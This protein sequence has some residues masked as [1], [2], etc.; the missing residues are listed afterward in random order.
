[1]VPPGQEGKR[2][3]QGQTHL[4]G[5]TCSWLCVH[6]V[7][8]YLLSEE[9]RYLTHSGNMLAKFLSSTVEYHQ[10]F[11]RAR[12]KNMKDKRLEAAE[13]IFKHLVCT[14]YC[15]Q[16]FTEVGKHFFRGFPNSLVFLSLLHLNHCNYIFKAYCWRLWP[17]WQGHVNSKWKSQKEH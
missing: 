9:N 1:M 10:P 3:L 5:L 2:D 6:E 11:S 8:C 7:L 13:N 15:V 12:T 14:R 4:L 16:D 17:L